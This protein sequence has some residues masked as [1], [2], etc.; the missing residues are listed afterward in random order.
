[1][2][3]AGPLYLLRHGETIWNRAKR[4]QGHRDTPLTL[5]GVQ[6]AEAMGQALAAELKGEAPAVFF[7]SPLG[8]TKQTAAIVADLIG[9]DPESIAHD[10]RLMEVTFGIW[11]GLNIEE[12]RAN[13]NEAW[14]S[15]LADRWRFI[16]PGGES[17]LQVGE[18]VGAFIADLP[19]E[20]PIVV[21]AHGAHNRVFRGLWR[22]LEPD[23]FLGLDEPQDGFYRL[24]PSGEESFI[25]A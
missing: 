1:M 6:Q 3:T 2:S 22:G 25:Q 13:H 8:R 17:Y 14:Q 15:R 19:S 4:L 16:P 9:F 24:D 20:N 18:R 5:K 12:L 10:D 23:E 11:D 21:V 7:G